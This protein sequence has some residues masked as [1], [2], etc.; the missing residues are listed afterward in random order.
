M[1]C[2]H[3]GAR[4]PENFHFCCV[5]G[6]QLPTPEEVAQ[7]ISRT[8][9]PQPE[10]PPDSP[11]PEAPVLEIPS[12]AEPEPDAPLSPESQ[13]EDIPQ[14]DAIPQAPVL[15]EAP[16][17]PFPPRP[18]KGRIWPPIV[19][20]VVMVCLGLTVFFLTAGRYQDPSMP[21]F[22]VTDG[23]LSFDSS[24][25]T[26]PEELTVPEYVGSAR[27]TALEAG[28]FADARRLTTVILPE[29]LTQIG[30]QAFSGCSSLRGVYIPEGV[31]TIGSQA[32]RGCDALEALYLPGSLD[33][34]AEDAFE[35]C[36]ALRHLIY[37]GSINS[38]QELFQG[39]IPT[40]A[41][42]HTNDGVFNQTPQSP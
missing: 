41:R 21:W 8:L 5:C 39:A 12:E 1:F 35:R 37:N 6:T 28:C 10:V 42:V 11:V 29:S 26:G 25:Y 20:M 30:D 23:V 2:P 7:L 13:A 22:T 24:K 33:T 36:D 15:P 14:D 9:E 27:V 17:S 38:W 32:F 40:D 19:I 16:E 3:C 31:T 4:C 18:K 34:V